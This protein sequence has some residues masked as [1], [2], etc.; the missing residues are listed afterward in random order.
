[1]TSVIPPGL[2][3]VVMGL[4]GVFFGA[5]G[6]RCTQ[7]N[8]AFNPKGAFR[9]TD[10]SQGGRLPG[11]GCYGSSYPKQASKREREREPARALLSSRGI[12]NSIP[13]KTK[14]TAARMAWRGALTGVL[15][16]SR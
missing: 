16:R 1:M 10:A 7:G 11:Q 5:V 2:A 3:T 9:R 8:V 13:R 14:N 4:A 15:L 12:C 6:S